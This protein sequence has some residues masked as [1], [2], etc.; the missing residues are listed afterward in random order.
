[1][2]TFAISMN[3]KQFNR[4]NDLIEQN[5]IKYYTSQ[6]DVYPLLIPNAIDR[7]PQYCKHFGIEGIV[8]TG[9]IDIDEE[10]ITAEYPTRKQKSR[11]RDSVEWQ[12][13]EM[14]VGLNLPVLGI[15]RGMQ[16]INLFFGGEV[17]LN[18]EKTMPGA[19]QHVAND[20]KVT[21]TNSDFQG[22]LQC[23]SLPVNSFHNHGLTKGSIA[24]G[25]REFAR[26]TE[27]NSV[28]GIFHPNYPI[29]GIQW[30]PERRS[31][32]SDHEFRL[33]KTFLTDGIF[34]KGI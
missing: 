7:I 5:Y 22:I 34:W 8:L 14:A 17:L 23:D 15:C 18:M 13:L 19:I 2:K 11:G 9:G 29:M 25:L 4:A 27:D 31:S 3:F 26:C 16:F 30:H 21:F 20:H 32:I 1:M 24:P 33:L 10:L 12:L 6:F 28:E